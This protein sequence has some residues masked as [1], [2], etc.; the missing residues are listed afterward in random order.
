MEKA[1]YREI[2]ETI[3]EQ[4]P[5]RVTIFVREAAAIMGADKDTVYEAINRVKNP[6]PC[7]KLSPRKYVIP[8]AALA[9]WMA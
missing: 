8:I 3:N 2:L 1:G 6:L 9:R 4:F 7:K 5:G